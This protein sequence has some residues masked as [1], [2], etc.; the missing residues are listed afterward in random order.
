MLPSPEYFLEQVGTMTTFILGI[1]LLH[2]VG[3]VGQKYSAAVESLSSNIYQQLA[4]NS[5]KDNI[6]VSPLSIHTAV[7][8]LQ[9]GT[10]GQS[11][12]QLQG[13]LGLTDIPKAEHLL[14]VSNL[15]NQYDNLKD[16]NMTL[17]IA[18]GVYGA[19]DMEV[20]NDFITLVENQFDGKYGKIDFSDKKSAVKTIN[21]WAANKTNNLIVDLVSEEA[22]DAEVRMVLMNAVYFKAKW[23]KPFDRRGTS[24]RVFRVPDQGDIMTEFMYLSDTIETA[25]L[26]ELGARLVSLPYIVPDYKL[27]IFHPDNLVR[28]EELE[29]R[30][31]SSNSSIADYLLRLEEK[32]CKLH[33]PKFDTGS[34]ISLVTPFQQLG[35]TDIFG[36]KADF[37]GITDEKNLKVGDI[38]HKTKLKITEEGSEAAAVTGA[39]LDIRSGPLHQLKI[40]INSPFIFFIQ[41]T[42]ENLPLF[43]GKI[44]NPTGMTVD[45]SLEPGE[46]IFTCPGGDLDACTDDCDYPDSR[47]HRICVGSCAKKC[48]DMKQENEEKDL[49]NNLIFAKKP[50]QKNDQSVGNK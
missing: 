4:K 48:P 8:M 7:S 33:L 31:F 46:R 41:D 13:A 14:E 49:E 44:V 12:Q 25:S 26:P 17:S 40:D 29:Q 50:E 45:K 15:Q 34:D 23:L 3:G 18:N 32:D 27:L 37:T 10:G 38:I 11:Q 28:I 22:L 42:K 24:E 19:N 21:T 20:H 47:K 36:D 30:L 9:Y 35:V 5:G 1:T 39:V 43:M 6:V 16:E 2:T